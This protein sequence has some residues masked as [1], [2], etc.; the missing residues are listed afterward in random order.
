MNNAL[1]TNTQ[2]KPI[3]PREIE[4]RAA[5]PL[6]GNRKGPMRGQHDCSDLDLFRVAN[7]PTL[8]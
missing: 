3:D 2:T 7:E 6:R 5:A 1:D 4:L 8:F